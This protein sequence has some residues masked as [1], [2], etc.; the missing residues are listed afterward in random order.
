MPQRVPSTL[1]SDA[2]K[3]AHGGTILHTGFF[4]LDGQN[5][6]GGLLIYKESDSREFYCG[7]L[8]SSS[9]VGV[10][11]GLGVLAFSDGVRYLGEWKQD[12]P[13][14]RGVETHPEL[15]TYAG[16]FTNDVRHGIGIMRCEGLMYC[17]CLLVICFL[18]VTQFECPFISYFLFFC[19]PVD[20]EVYCTWVLC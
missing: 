20:Y 12:V 6:S 1:S 14:G 17:K 11:E 16:E 3:A 5:M 10:R 2:L 15:G 8:Q 9:G 13:S 19:V 7:G 18:L 4:A